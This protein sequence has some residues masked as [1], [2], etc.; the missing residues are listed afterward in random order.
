MDNHD[1]DETAGDLLFTSFGAVDVN[2]IAEVLDATTLTRL[3][4]LKSDITFNVVTGS[5]II[6]QYDC[7]SYFTS[8]F[9]TL[10]PY[11]TGKRR[12]SRRENKP[13]SLLA[14]VA[15]MLRHSSRSVS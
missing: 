5:K 8:P 14:W 3:V 1:D 11:G 10:F 13:L 6:N 2:N 7:D 4:Q 9:P 12:D 15:L